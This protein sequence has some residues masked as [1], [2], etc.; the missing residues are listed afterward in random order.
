M[1]PF[2][3]NVALA[4][5]LFALTTLAGCDKATQ[6][7][8]QISAAAE[9]VDTHSEDEKFND[10]IDGFNKLVDGSKGLKN[11]REQYARQNIA[12]ATADA[13]FDFD[14]V[15]GCDPDGIKD[16]VAALK[17]GRGI[18][19]PSAAK[20]DAA[21]DAV[22]KP[23][24][25]LDTQW[26]ALAPYYLQKAY[27]TDALARGKAADAGILADYD[28]AIAAIDALDAELSAHQKAQTLKTLE[29]MKAQGR[30]V[31]Y[32]VADI[33]RISEALITISEK[34]QFDATNKL[35]TELEAADQAFHAA[36]ADVKPGDA[37]FTC[38]SLM[39]KHASYIL[40]SYR[41]FA[42]DKDES[43]YNRLVSS[44][45]TAIE[46]YSEHCTD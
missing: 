19:V 11:C 38:A 26:R 37:D 10:Y 32:H 39:D 7:G 13:D 40:G 12:N 14:G 46:T 18:S 8:N 22:L 29:R 33:M 9:D 35:A 28:A 2:S 30:M 5:A 27:R 23:L 36:S 1:K 20:A 4:A 41:D 34:Q 44:Y 25:H 17:K 45:N 16:I 31:Q 43:S 42:R 24:E 3:S 21:V 6:L 15:L